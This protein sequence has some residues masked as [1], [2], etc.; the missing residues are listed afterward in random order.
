M[1]ASDQG[2]RPERYTVIPRT[3]IFLT[4]TSGEHPPAWTEVLLLQGAPTKRLWANKYNG[5]GG[6]I[7]KGEDVLN[8]A[9][10]EL[11]E[12]TGLQAEQLWLAGTLLVDVG[13]DVGVA[14]YVLCGECTCAEEVKSSNEGRLEWVDLASLGDFDL[15][16]DLPVLLP[17]AL[18]VKAGHAPFSARSY[19]TEDG[20]L[21]LVFA[22]ES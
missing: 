22:P 10:R 12:E 7:E 19:Y 21:E 9:R 14:V 15:V 3:L 2:V 11:Q 17:R 5:I 4:R 18:A 1:P 13:G 8:A 16:D 6:H 20:R